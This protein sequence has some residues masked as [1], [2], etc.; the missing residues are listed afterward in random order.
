MAPD[1]VEITKR[2]EFTLRGV[3]SR[4]FCTLAAQKRNPMKRSLLIPN[5]GVAVFPLC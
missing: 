2:S 1:P 3:E 5:S 4:M